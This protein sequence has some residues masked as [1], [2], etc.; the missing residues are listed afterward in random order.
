[1]WICQVC[2]RH[3]VTGVMAEAGTLSAGARRIPRIPLVL[4]LILSLG[5]Q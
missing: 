3:V 1:M 2:A 5:I 4:L